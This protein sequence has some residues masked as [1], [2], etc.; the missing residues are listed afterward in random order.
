MLEL[1][2]SRPNPIQERVHIHGENS[3]GSDGPEVPKLSLPLEAFVI[4][5]KDGWLIQSPVDQALKQRLGYEKKAQPEGGD[6]D[7]PRSARAHLVGPGTGHEYMEGIAHTSQ[8]MNL[9]YQAAVEE[10]LRGLREWLIEN[11][12]NAPIKLWHRAMSK[13]EAKVHTATGTDYEVL[14]EVHYKIFLSAPG[15]ESAVLAEVDFEIDSDLEAV[16][17]FDLRV[18]DSRYI[19]LVIDAIETRKEKK[20]AAMKAAL[21][22]GKGK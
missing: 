1:A 11:M 5:V 10:M 15:Y 17:I 3:P 13:E 9:V 12:P 7:R 16:P 6:I 18:P 20:L 8:D 19:P 21:A 22:K 14:R 2:V 4:K